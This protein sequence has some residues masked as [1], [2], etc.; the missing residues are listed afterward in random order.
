MSGCLAD[1][2]RA[3]PNG[4]ERMDRSL[5]VGCWQ[6]ALPMVPA[7]TT[8]N[9][10]RDTTSTFVDNMR[11]PVHRWYRFSAGYSADWVKAVL[12]SESKVGAVFD[13]FAGSGTTLLAARES[14]YD[15]WGVEAHPFVSRIAA[16]KL[17]SSTPPDEYREFTWRMIS[18]AAQTKPDICHYPPLIHKCFPEAQLSVLDQLRRAWEDSRDDSPASELAWLTLV[19]TLRKAASAGTAPWQYVLP[20][21]KKRNPPEGAAAFEAVAEMFYSDMVVA[22]GWGATPV[23]L[24]RSDARTCEGVPDGEMD[25]VITSPP[26]ANNYDYADATRLEMSFMGEVQRWGD[27]Q[28]TVRRHLLVSCSQHVSDR[29]TSLGGVLDDPAVLPIRDELESVTSQLAEIRLEKGGRKAYHLMI[30]CY[31]RD[32]ALVWKSLRRV[33]RTGSRVCF[34]IGDSAPYGIYVPVIEWFVA[35]AQANGFGEWTFEKTRDRNVKWKNRKH[36]VPLV[37]GRL[38]IQG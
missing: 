23:S 3:A 18:E 29:T 28:E 6:Y 4:S 22:S 21:K 7:T 34:V 10:Q 30:A 5:A 35:L 37:E 8:R 38:W 33:C 2:N 14:G 12:A 26:Y 36:R 25:L 16:A 24:I 1:R 15:S 11:L 32:M 20:N 13:P 31:F 27:L 17:L 19:V 9:S